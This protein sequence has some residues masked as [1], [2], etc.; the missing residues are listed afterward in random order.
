MSL[1]LLAPWALVALVALVI[2][3]VI[4]WQ[5]G[6]PRRT[7]PFAPRHLVPQTA[8]P[9]R[10]RTL[11]AL[12]LL[13]LRCLLLAALALL[14]A[15]PIVRDA[16]GAATFVH[17]GISLTLPDAGARWL[18]PGF[19]S[20]AQ[21]PVEGWQRTSIA[22]LVRELDARLPA[23]V[24]LE[25]I[26][27]AQG[28][29]LDDARPITARTVHIRAVDGAAERAALGKALTIEVL[30]LSAATSGTGPAAGPTDLSALLAAFGSAASSADALSVRLVDEPSASRNSDPRSLLVARE[31]TDRELPGSVLQFAERGGRVL[32]F[33][34]SSGPGVAPLSA[35]IEAEAFLAVIQ[36][37][38]R[39]VGD[40][41][42]WIATLPWRYDRREL[43]LLIQDDWPSVLA[44]AFGRS[45]P[46]P[47]VGRS[48]DLEPLA[49]STAS[50]GRL[51]GS[52]A[53]RLP[54][55]SQQRFDDWLKWII[56]L[57]FVAERAL[58]WRL[59]R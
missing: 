12:L 22:S 7:V 50:S 54:L 36:A 39:V 53:N 6:R 59:G 3:L 35:G 41:G 48:V 38:R 37:K 43:P 13:A 45:V 10:R 25:L 5:R 52:A 42:G 19:P 58:A 33:A 29:V 49:P 34:G 18:A 21:R 4:H 9:Q 1:A 44:A 26:V 17:P 56:A 24:P 40:R 32:E 2:P 47:A 30:D 28:L 55:V 11:E 15:V 20:L 51:R 8:S 23:D 14:L 57:L 16:P 27:P 31:R 46:L